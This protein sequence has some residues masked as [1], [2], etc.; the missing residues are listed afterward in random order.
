M[1]LTDSIDIDAAPDIVWNVWRDVARWPEW[2][3]SIAKVDLLDSGPLRV[4][5]RARIRQPK[6]PI[7]VWR[8]TSVNEP[9][10]SDDI[11]FT[12]VSTS[13]GSRVTGDHRIEVNGSGSRAVL[14]VDF[15]GPL[16]LI[17][18]FLTRQLSLR[19][20][21]MEATGLKKRSEGLASRK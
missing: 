1:K 14:S 19:Y 4:G 17:V 5:V 13:P 6:L 10:T 11:G 16:A 20:L 12:W 7:A 18:A 15:R 9:G 8:V 2:T 21:R 3:A